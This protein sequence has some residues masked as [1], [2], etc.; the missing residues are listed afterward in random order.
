MNVTMLVLDI[1]VLFTLDDPDD[2]LDVLDLKRIVFDPFRK[3]RIEDEVSDLVEP[4]LLEVI[5]LL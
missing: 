3:N 5:H 2:L 1:T 4:S